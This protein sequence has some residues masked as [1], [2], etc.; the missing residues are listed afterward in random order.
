LALLNQH[1]SQFGLTPAAYSLVSDSNPQ[2]HG[3]LFLATPH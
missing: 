3:T 2:N 1:A